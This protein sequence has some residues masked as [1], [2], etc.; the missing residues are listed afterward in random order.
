MYVAFGS[1][2][3]QFMWVVVWSYAAL[4]AIDYGRHGG[5]VLLLVSFFWTSQ[6]IK[7]IVHVTVAGTVAAHVLPQRRGALMGPAALFHEMA[8]CPLW[9]STVALKAATMSARGTHC[10]HQ[11]RAQRQIGRV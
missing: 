7:N 9:C 4:A 2:L 6:V 11:A 8:D 10:S 5:F 1:A 3:L